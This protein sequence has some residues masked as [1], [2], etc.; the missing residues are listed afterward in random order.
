[1]LLVW[2]RCAVLAGSLSQAELLQDAAVPYGELLSIYKGLG[3][4]K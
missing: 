4:M 2:L 1:M 3:E